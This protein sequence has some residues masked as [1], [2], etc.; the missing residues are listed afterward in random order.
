MDDPGIHPCSEN[1]L[2]MLKPH[3][4]Q[5]KLEL[6][7]SVRGINGIARKGQKRHRDIVTSGRFDQT[8]QFHCQNSLLRTAIF[9]IPKTA[10][11][12]RA[13]GLAG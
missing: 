9:R 10:C 8:S 3:E 6:F 4:W 1:P 12:G 5:K 2:K 13:I 7:I 11:H